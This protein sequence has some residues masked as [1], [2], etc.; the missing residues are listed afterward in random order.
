ML[1]PRLAVSLMNNNS[2]K[3][4]TNPPSPLESSPAP[5][6]LAFAILVSVSSNLRRRGWRGLV[7]SHYNPCC[8]YR[9]CY[10]RWDMSHQTYSLPTRHAQT[11]LLAGR[12][13]SHVTLPWGV[14]RLVY[15]GHIPFQGCP[16]LHVEKSRHSSR[17]L[18]TLNG[19]SRLL[20]RV[21]Q[22][23]ATIRRVPCRHL[24]I[25]LC[26]ITGPLGVGVECGQGK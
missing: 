24:T 25:V 26:T 22:A 11:L 15:H 14:D 16:C 18:Q 4:T 9:W 13:R 10:L 8:P 5:C 3:T 7:K 12:V 19:F 23:R 6:H 21:G 2:V 1:P 20:G 17:V